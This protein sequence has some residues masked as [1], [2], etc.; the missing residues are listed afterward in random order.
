MFLKID[1]EEYSFLITYKLIEAFQSNS[2]KGVTT[3]EI[4]R[5]QNNQVSLNRSTAINNL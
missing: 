1:K 5:Y 3:L 4:L 2:I